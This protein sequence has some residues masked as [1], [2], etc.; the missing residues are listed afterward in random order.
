MKYLKRFESNG[1]KEPIDVELDIEKFWEV[2]GEKIKSYDIKRPPSKPEWGKEYQ[3]RS[4]I[5]KLTEEFGVTMTDDWNYYNVYNADDYGRNT[6]DIMVVKAV[7]NQHAKLK[8]A[9]IKNNL[10][11]FSTGFYLVKKVDLDKEILDTENQ[12]KSLQKKLNELNN[13]P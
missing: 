11:I 2:F 3:I 6:G 4:M 10:E 7:N 8:V 1:Y 12:I 5:N 9:T 13:I